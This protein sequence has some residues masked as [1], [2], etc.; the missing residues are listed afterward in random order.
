[1]EG[2]VKTSLPPHTEG[3]KAGTTVGEGVSRG[4]IPVLDL[5]WKSYDSL[6]LKIL[7]NLAGRRM[8]KRRCYLSKINIYK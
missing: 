1:M 8:R 6:P 5:V 2:Q 7:E 4:K 3:T